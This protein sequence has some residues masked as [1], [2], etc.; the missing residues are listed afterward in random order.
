MAYND[1]APRQMFKGDWKC[2]KCGAPITEL[3]FEPDPSRLGSL[4]C[5]DCHRER[6]NSFGG[7]R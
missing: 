4:L 2:S 3:P 6:R 5:R 1:N 7:R